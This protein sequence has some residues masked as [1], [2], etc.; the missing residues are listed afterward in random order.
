[1]GERVYIPSLGRFLSVDPVEGGTA[2]NYA[3]PNDPVNDFDLSGQF[4]MKD[5]ANVASIGSMIPGPIGMA[6]AAVAAAAYAK[7]GDKKQAM[8]MAG[9][10]VA[11]GVGAG[12]VVGGVKAFQAIKQSQNVARAARVVAMPAKN[13]AR[14]VTKERWISPKVRVSPLGNWS[15]KHGNGKPYVAARLPHYHY[16]KK[17]FRGKPIAGQGMGK[18]R[19]WQTTF[20]RWFR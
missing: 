7:A 20:K 1:M 13:A 15:A 9:S 8:I 16:A 10:I 3:Y 4:G 14:S 12:A 18:H 17:D 5:F 19:P 2:N 6:S 11:A